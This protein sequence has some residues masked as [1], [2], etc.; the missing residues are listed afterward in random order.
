M[1]TRGPKG[2]RSNF[3]KGHLADEDRSLGT[4][5]TLGAWR[6]NYVALEAHKAVFDVFEGT[7]IS[8]RFP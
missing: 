3:G 4:Q 5:N 7:K 6:K 1:G 2:A 8:A